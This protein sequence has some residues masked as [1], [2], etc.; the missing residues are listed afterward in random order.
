MQYCIGIV[1]RNKCLSSGSFTRFSCSSRHVAFHRVVPTSC[2]A[3]STYF[4][5]RNL[6]PRVRKPKLENGQSICSL[7]HVK[8]CMDLYSLSCPSADGVGL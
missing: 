2:R 8:K 5:T 4:S 7:F 6:F 1:M 3:H